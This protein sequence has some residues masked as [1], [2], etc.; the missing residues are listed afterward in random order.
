VIGF[1]N[2]IVMKKRNVKPKS[3]LNN[4]SVNG[5]NLEYRRFIL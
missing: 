3:I 5:S 1:M 4:K 2:R